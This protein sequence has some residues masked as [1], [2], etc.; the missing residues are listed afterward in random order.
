MMKTIAALPGGDRQGRGLS[1]RDPLQLGRLGEAG[2]LYLL[3]LVGR[4]QPGRDG[5]E[6][7][8]ARFGDETHMGPDGRRTVISTMWRKVGA[9]AYE[10]MSRSAADPTGS[11]VVRYRRVG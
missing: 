10:T 11:R 6:A 4:G 5:G 9:D 8:R 2:R 3:E 1:Q 7:G